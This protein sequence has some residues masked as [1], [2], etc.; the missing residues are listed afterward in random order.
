TFRHTINRVSPTGAITVLAGDP[1]HPG[2][3]DGVGAAAQ[4]EFPTGLALD[5]GTLYVADFDRVRAIDLASQ[6]V[7]TITTGLVFA[8][9]IAADHGGHLYVTDPGAHAVVKIEIVTGS[10]TTVGTFDAPSGIVY[11]GGEAL[12]VAESGAAL[13]KKVD[14]VSGA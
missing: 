9:G 2:F 8:Q 3:D 13:V 4:L 11:D 6:A 14:L 1:Q 10:V 12:Y 7:T 5:G